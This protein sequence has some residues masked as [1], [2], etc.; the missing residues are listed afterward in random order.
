MVLKLKRHHRKG[1]SIVSIKHFMRLR[2]SAIA[3]SSPSF[4][5][6]LKIDPTDTTLS[7]ESI[8]RVP[9][10]FHAR[11]PVSVNG[12]AARVFGLWP[13]TCRPASNVADLIQEID[14]RK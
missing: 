12:L 2:V 4:P 1:F 7:W 5:L 6:N 11:F 13:K 10:A 9:E 3:A 14:P 8:P